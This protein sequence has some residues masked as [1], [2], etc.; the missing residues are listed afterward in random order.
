MRY[1]CS[2]YGCLGR[3]RPSLDASPPGGCPDELSVLRLDG[4]VRT[5]EAADVGPAPV[6]CAHPEAAGAFEAAQIPTQ[7]PAHTHAHHALVTAVRTG[8]T[9]PETVLN[10][11]IKLK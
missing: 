10:K 3:C 7:S 1:L 5:V 2:E 11:K 8:H 6:S 4:V 9:G